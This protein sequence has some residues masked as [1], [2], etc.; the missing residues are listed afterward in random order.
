MTRL[1]LT[2]REWETIVIDGPCR[3]TVIRILR[4]RVKMT[5]EAERSVKILRGEIVDRMPRCTPT[6]AAGDRATA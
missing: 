1:A 6:T 5:V 2:R 4:D 3:I